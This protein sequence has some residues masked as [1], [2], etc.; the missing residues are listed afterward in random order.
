M[1]GSNYGNRESLSVL[2]IKNEQAQL[3]FLFVLGGMFSYREAI[4]KGQPRLNSHY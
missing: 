2:T 4:S 3:F 1:S